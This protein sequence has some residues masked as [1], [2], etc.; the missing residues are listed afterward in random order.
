M[1][2]SRLD[3]VSFAAA[4]SALAALGRPARTAELRQRGVSERELTRATRSGEVIR[5]RNGVYAL[6]DTHEAVLHAAEHGG[7]PGCRAAARLYGLWT[8]AEP[9][10]PHVWLGRTGTPRPVPDRCRIHWDEGVVRVGV[11]PPVANVLLQIAVCAGAEEFFVALES[12]LRWN[13]LRPG[14][15]AWLRARLP[16]RM[17]WL[18]GFARADADSGLESLIR[19]RLAPHG[20][21][22]RTQVSIR[23]VGEVDFVIRGWLI[24]EADGKANHD[25]PLRHKDLVRDARAA[26]QGYVTLRFDYALIVHDWPL[27]EAAILGALRRGRPALRD[28]VGAGRRGRQ[29]RGDS[30]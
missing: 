26:A 23:G 11:L 8:L 5:I 22:P 20:I 19:L 27:V 13:L 6:P 25:G 28:E 1:R 4:A 3:D 9:D 29:V 7:V 16:A 14:A 24:V 17:R 21:H 15:V 12:A 30:R 2:P 18:V 10:Q